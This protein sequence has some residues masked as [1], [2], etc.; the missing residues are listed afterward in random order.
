VQDL[1]GAALLLGSPTGPTAVTEVSRALHRAV[2]D[3][4]D[5]LVELHP[6]EITSDTVAELIAESASRSCPDQVVSV[7]AK[8]T[9]PVPVEVAAFLYRCARECTVNVAKHARATEVRITLDSDADGV[10]LV[11]RDDGIGIPDP[12]PT[13]EGHLGLTLLRESAVDLGGTLALRAAHPG[14]VVTLTLP[15]APG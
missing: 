2:G 7:T 10:R 9:R 1:A 6:D 15:P 14:T 5:M 11:V 3:L 4:R 8:L 12:V 13:P